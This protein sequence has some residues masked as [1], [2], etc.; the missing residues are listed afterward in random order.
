MIYGP[1]AVQCFILLPMTRLSTPI[2]LFR[3]PPYRLAAIRSRTPRPFTPFTG[4]LFLFHHGSPCRWR[5]PG[6]RAADRRSISLPVSTV[7]PVRSLLPSRALR[8][9]PLL[10]TIETEPDRSLMRPNLAASAAVLTKASVEA[11][12]TAIKRAQ[13]FMTPLRSR[14]NVWPVIDKQGVFLKTR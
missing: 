4:R 10:L 7:S 5:T 3:F 11:R 14:R 6:T 12:A 8:S 13:T 1:N 2:Y 9:S